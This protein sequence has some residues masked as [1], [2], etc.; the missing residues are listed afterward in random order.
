M[1][2]LEL[3]RKGMIAAPQRGRVMMRALRPIRYTGGALLGWLLFCY[4]IQTFVPDII[5]FIVAM[6]GSKLFFPIFGAVT[7]AC[8]G[9][10]LMAVARC[11]HKLAL[12][13][14]DLRA[15]Q[16]VWTEGRTSPSR[17]E[18]EGLGL[19]RLYGE[20]RTTWWYVVKDK[21]FEV[22]EEAHRTL[23]PGKFR[24]YHTPRSEMLLSIEPA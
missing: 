4:A 6:L 19:A 24:L 18:D 12:L 17:E 13:I 15:G 20:H 2:D 23:P 8:T 7:L 5:L 10:F 9:A 22:S 14:A 21:Y 11:S 3:N 16:A 1:T